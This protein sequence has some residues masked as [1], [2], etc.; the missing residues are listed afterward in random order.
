MIFNIVGL[1][2]IANLI[3]HWFEPIQEYKTRFLLFIGSKTIHTI[4]TC[5]KCLGLYLGLVF[6][7]FYTGFTSPY[8]FFHT[9]AFGAMVSLTSYLIK[10]IIDYIELYYEQ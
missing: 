9:L 4:L 10:F 3:T 5:P 2:I 1:A 7:A 8:Y 6:N